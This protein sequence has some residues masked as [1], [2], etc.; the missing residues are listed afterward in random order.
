MPILLAPLIEPIVKYGA[1]LLVILGVIF[2]VKRLLNKAQDAEAYARALHVTREREK[3]DTRIRAMLD[4]AL[5]DELR[6]ARDRHKR[7][8]W[9]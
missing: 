6:K 8:G 1:I 2:G 5:D 4:A 9:Q 7:K 3:A